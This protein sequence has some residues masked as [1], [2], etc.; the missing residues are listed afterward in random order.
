M[1]ELLQYLSTLSSLI[2]GMVFCVHLFLFF[3]LWLWSRRDLKKIASALFD[4]TRGLKNQSLLDST[5]HL[6]D[7]IDAF[8]SDVNDV[9]DEADRQADRRALLER[10]RVLDEKRRYLNS[11]FFETTYNMGRTMIEAYPLAGVLGT[12]LAIGVALQTSAATQSTAT[13]GIILGRFGDAIW[14]TA[15]GLL[16]AMI[17]MFVNSCLEPAFNRLSENRQH[18]RET[19]SRVKRELAFVPS[20][21]EEDEE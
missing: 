8:L 14:S 13:V 21:S 12:I 5:A 4:F 6:S 10:M 15:A 3:V 2:I 9:L 11:M 7:Q 20:A 19:V 17:L 1:N 16:A 18:V